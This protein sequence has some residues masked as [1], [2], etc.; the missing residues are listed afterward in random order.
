MEGRMK[1]ALSWARQRMW[2]NK[3]ILRCLEEKRAEAGKERQVVGRLD[4]FCGL[5]QEG[6]KETVNIQVKHRAYLELP[7]SRSGGI[8]DIKGW[9]LSGAWCIDIWAEKSITD[10]LHSLWV[11]G[12]TI[13]KKQ[14]GSIRCAATTAWTFPSLTWTLLHLQLNKGINWTN[15][16]RTELNAA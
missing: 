4:S 7:G 14:E 1:K 11:G 13:C 12:R 6:K 5:R 9:W 10:G 15:A 8:Y 3:S 2:K 16:C